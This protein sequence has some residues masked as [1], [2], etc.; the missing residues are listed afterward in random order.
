MVTK[1][2]EQVTKSYQNLSKSYQ[3]LALSYQKLLKELPKVTYNDD[4]SYQKDDVIFM[5]RSNKLLLR[6]EYLWRGVAALLFYEATNCLPRTDKNLAI[7]WQMTLEIPV[8]TLKC[9]WNT[10]NNPRNSYKTIRNSYRTYLCYKGQP[11]ATMPKAGAPFGAICGLKAT[12]YV[13]IPR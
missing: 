7:N 3:N 9:T 10:C 8:I 6:T 13:I 11:T 5:L 12:K 4:K 1:S 2:R